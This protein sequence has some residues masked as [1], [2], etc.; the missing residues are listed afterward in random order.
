MIQKNI[1]HYSKLFTEYTE[2]RIQENRDLGIV[3]VNGDIVKN[4]KAAVSGVSARV[5]KDGVWGFS[6]NSD[7]SDETVK[8]VIKSAAD[9]A[10]FLNS[11]EKR[12][13]GG[14][15]MANAVSEND[16]ST[17]KH[18]KSQKDLIEFINF[19]LRFQL[20]KTKSRL[21]YQMFTVDLV[22]LKIIFQIQIFF[23]KR[24][25]PNTSIF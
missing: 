2:L 9:N 1:S 3:M 23:L 25:M 6:S 18:K 5:Y 22:N 8:Q 19:I 12:K 20:K 17:K 11:K 14:L 15:P 7:F 13:A 16:F 10:L 4:A 21:N 24:L